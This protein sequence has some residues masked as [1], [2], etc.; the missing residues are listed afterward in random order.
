MVLIPVS[1]CLR[2]FDGFRWFS[3]LRLREF[4]VSGFRASGFTV[5]G[6]GFTV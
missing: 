4:G 5:W 6:L 2:R 1:F 3:G